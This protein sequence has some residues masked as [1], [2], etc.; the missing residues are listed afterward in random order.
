MALCA[1][2]AK[3]KE[4]VSE[5]PAFPQQ[6]DSGLGEGLQI[7]DRATVSG[8]KGFASRVRASYRSPRA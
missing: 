2:L 6:S 3:W 7:Y 8:K 5:T 4:S 1:F